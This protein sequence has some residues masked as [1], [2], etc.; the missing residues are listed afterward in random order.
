MEQKREVGGDNEMLPIKIFTLCGCVY[1]YTYVMYVSLRLRRRASNIKPPQL[2]KAERRHI[3][4]VATVV[5]CL[6]SLED[7]G[8][9]HFV[10]WDSP[11]LL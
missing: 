2:Q 9:F 8:I 4:F 5:V 11:R 10:R 6:L 3:R 1:T 7:A